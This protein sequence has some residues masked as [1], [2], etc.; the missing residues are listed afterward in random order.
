[1]FLA[2]LEFLAR[3]NLPCPKRSEPDDTG[4]N[5]RAELLCSAFCAKLSEPDRFQPFAF[6]FMDLSTREQGSINAGVNTVKLVGLD[7]GTTTSSAVI[8]SAQLLLN[9]VTGRTEPANIREC[10][11][12]RIAL[13]PFAGNRL[14]LRQLTQYVEDWLAAGGVERDNI[15]GGGALLT[16][17]AAQAQ[18]AAGLVQLVRERMPDAFVAS[19][20]DPCLESWLAFMGSCAGLSRAHPERWFLN[21]DIGGGTT[22]LALGRD[23]EVLNTGCLFVGARHI[24]V[25]PGSY[26]II[27]LSPYARR[28]LRHLG[29]EKDQG[30]ELTRDE[31]KAVLDY[32]LLLLEAA[33]TGRHEVFDEP[34]ARFHQQIAF[35]PRSPSCQ[36]D[37]LVV[38]LSGGVGELV[39]AAAQGRAWP[40]TTHFG[41]LGIDFA[42]RLLDASP[43]STDFRTYLPAGGGRATVYGL[44]RHSTQ[45]SGNTVFLSDSGL[46][47][48]CELPIF[49]MLTE[50][51]SEDHVHSLIDMVQKSPRGGCLQ[52]QVAAGNFS[53]VRGLGTRISRALEAGRFPCNHPLVF[54]A[55]ENLGKAL[56]QYISRWGSLPLRLAV[57]DEIKIPQA[58]Y[59]H[60]GKLHNQVIPVSF[61]GLQAREEHR[62][63]R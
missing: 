62:C 39:Y 3:Q 45:V 18:N 24:K 14:D 40:S 29:I 32:Y 43:R 53:A 35:R 44:L 38:T 20:D 22:N 21:L 11:R 25:V 9:A 5:S 42:A 17:L 55:E 52:V 54:L 28:L 50:A 30:A 10:H 27:D 51:S 4:C 16:G 7:F 46:L 56:G 15:F 12:S 63:D 2:R 1:M 57:I 59:V 8:A 6:L 58:Q 47:P 19:A 34:V 37:A 31:V 33:V 36:S 49:G 61:Y 48:L 26:R 41:D 13:T 23:G 60:L